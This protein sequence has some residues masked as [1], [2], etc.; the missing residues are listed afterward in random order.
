MDRGGVETWLMQVMRHM[1]RTRFEFHF[2]CLSGR[3]GVYAE[4]I[5]ELGGKVLP[6]P[7][8]KNLLQF[9]RRFDALLDSE[10]YQIVH[11]HVHG[12]SGYILWRAS[13]KAV[14]QRIAHSFTDPSQVDLSLWRQGYEQAM[15][16]MIRRYATL[17]LG[18]SERSMI[19]LFGEDW[20]NDPRWQLMY[21]GTDLARFQH[22]TDSAEVR[23][24]LQIPHNAPVIGHVGRLSPV[25]NH[26]FILEIARALAQQRKDTWFLLVGDGPLR[27]ELECRAKELGLSQVVFTG[28]VEEAEPYYLAMDLFLFPSLWEGLP[29]S[30][31][32]AQAAGLRC[33]CSDA[34]TPEVGVV[35]DAVQFLPL[36]VGVEKWAQT[37]LLMLGQPKLQ[38]VSTLNH[39]TESPFS[40]G[41]SVE[42]LAFFYDNQQAPHWGNSPF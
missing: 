17:G 30:V 35:P 9:N 24:W 15:H 39:L 21:C 1:D 12:F 29:Q 19:S 22:A 34:V 5:E 18:N 38:Q 20:R 11:S 27:T 23:S 31:I 3:R 37:C 36:S 16:Y 41:K 4:E 6:C 32:E 33:L 13:K 14:R 42:R 8:S 26:H 10:Q 2:C 7:L 25:K 40:I 28:P